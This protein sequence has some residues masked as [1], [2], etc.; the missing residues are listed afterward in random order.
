[1]KGAGAR[2]SS[3]PLGGVHPIVGAEGSMSGWVGMPEG[4][5]AG[6]GM[7]QKRYEW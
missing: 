1:M 6:E 5:V 2:G 7:V 4:R 3:D